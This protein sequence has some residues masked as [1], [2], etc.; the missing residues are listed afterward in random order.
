MDN[1]NGKVG[2][3]LFWVGAVYIVVMAGLAGVVVPRH[4]IAA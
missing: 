2:L 3:V 1:Q 4:A